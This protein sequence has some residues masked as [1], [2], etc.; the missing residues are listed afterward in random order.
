VFIYMLPPIGELP[1]V[2]TIG[3]G[4]AWY[5]AAVWFERAR[6]TLPVMAPRN[7]LFFVFLLG[8][9]RAAAIP[10]APRAPP[11]APE[12]VREGCDVPESTLRDATEEKVGV[13]D[14]GPAV[15]LETWTWRP[16]A[17]EKYVIWVTCRGEDAH[18]VCALAV[19]RETSG[20]GF[21]RPQAFS[22]VGFSKATLTLIAPDKLRFDGTDEK[23]NWTQ[24]LDDS[25]DGPLFGA[26][27]Y[28]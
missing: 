3:G 18:R 10:P 25:N 26:R 9:S 14:M 19:A 5:R 23:G 17:E 7:V 11:E 20:S 13:S 2:F 15:V 28:H 21:V 27:T 12:V 4:A 6:G 1:M 16:R 22:H 24:S 8:C